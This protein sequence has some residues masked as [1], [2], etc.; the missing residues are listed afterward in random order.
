MTI[1]MDVQ[2]EHYLSKLSNNS[3]YS[4]KEYNITLQSHYFLIYT[5]GSQ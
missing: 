4:F 1:T 2:A 5:D 3:K